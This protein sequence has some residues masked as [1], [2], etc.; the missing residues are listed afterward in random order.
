[1]PD[2]DGNFSDVSLGYDNVDDY[3]LE[4]NP[5]FGATVGR[6]ANRIANSSFTIDGVT[7]NLTKNRGEHHLH[8]GIKVS[9]LELFQSKSF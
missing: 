8:G 1:V 9:S 7:Y 2:K 3:L 5:Y 6:V 4:N